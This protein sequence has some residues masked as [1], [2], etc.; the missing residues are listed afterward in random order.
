LPLSRRGSLM[1][2][3]EPDVTLTDVGLAIECGIIAVLLGRQPPRRRA[4]RR[5]FIGF[6]VATGVAALGGAVAHGFVV[7]KQSI[8][9]AAVW[10]ITLLGIGTAALAAWGA[11]ACLAL[12]GAWVRRVPR[13][14]TIGFGVYAAIVVFFSQGFGVAVA[15]YV[16]AAVF[17]SL[18]FLVAYRRAPERYLL[19]GL[20]G[21]V[22]TFAGTAIQQTRLG[23][24][25]SYFDHNAVYHLVVGVG[26]VLIY[27]AGRGVLLSTAGGG[28]DAC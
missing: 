10:T 20:A 28:I 19:A 22:L 12:S 14:A 6:F 2:V 24:H 18:T 17:L 25:P 8:A 4:L 3:M 1:T 7:D 15:F 16:P 23:L 26:L 9:H 13:T 5:W 11:G 27:R 21:M